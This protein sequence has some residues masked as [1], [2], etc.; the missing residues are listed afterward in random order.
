MAFTKKEDESP[1]INQNKEV[2]ED[3]FKLT[4]ASTLFD[5][6]IQ[7]KMKASFG[8]HTSNIKEVNSFIISSENSNFFAID[9]LNK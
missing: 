1:K 9:A 7:K 2:A 5:L 6:D 4:L 8:A 3:L